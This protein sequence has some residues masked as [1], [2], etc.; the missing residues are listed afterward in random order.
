MSRSAADLAVSLDILAGPDPDETLLTLNLPKPRFTGLKD[1]RVAV[2]ADQPGTSTDHETRDAILAL[3]NDLEKQGVTVDRAARP[4]FDPIEAYHLYLQLLSSAWSIRMTEHALE[5]GRERLKTLAEDNMNADAIML[6]TTDMTHRA[7]L[8]LNEKR[9]KLH[10]AWSA[11]FRDHDVLLCPAFGTAALPHRQDGQT[12]QRRIVVEGQEIAY[13]DLLFWPGITGGYHLPAT[14][15]PMGFTQAGLPLGVQ[16]A[17]PVYGDR[18]TI[19][20]AILI[21]QAG[22]IFVP[23]AGW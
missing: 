14:V 15:A 17:G 4:A 13:N 2:W 19:A 22:K 3:A 12:W 21:E 20:A 10:R 8:A 1:L 11:F 18:S 7:W 5:S 9:H 6:R 23:P 16:I